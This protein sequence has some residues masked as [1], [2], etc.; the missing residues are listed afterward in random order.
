MKLLMILVFITGSINCLGFEYDSNNFDSLGKPLNLVEMP[1][2][3][4]NFYGDITAALP[5]RKNTV[6]VHPDYFT[7]GNTTV[8]LGL[9]AEDVKVTFLHEGAG[10]KNSFGYIA[11]TDTQPTIDDIKENGILIFPNASLQ[12]SGGN[13]AYGDTYSLGSFPQGTKLLFFV[14]ANTWNNGSIAD[15]S[16]IFTTDSDLNQESGDMNFIPLKQHVAMLW[17]EESE[18]VVLG[19]EDVL[20]TESWCD[21][22]FNDVMFTVS[23]VPANAINSNIITAV[24]EPTAINDNITYSSGI[25]AYEDLWPNTGDYDFN[26]I[27]MFYTIAQTKVNSDVVSIKYEVTPQAMGA[28]FSNKYQLKLNTPLENIKNIQKSFNGDAFDFVKDGVVVNSNLVF[29]DGNGTVIEMI[30][31][32]KGAIPPP[33]NYHMSNTIKNS[34]AVFGTKIT[35][36]IVFYNGVHADTLGAP[37]YDSYISRIDDQGRLIEVHQVGKAPTTKADLSL[38]GTGDDDSNPATGKYY[39]TYDNKPWVI[40]IPGNWDNPLEKI[41]IDQPYSDLLQWIVSNGSNNKDWYTKNINNALI[42]RK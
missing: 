35:L 40:L 30:D 1:S 34:P 32:V 22:D 4:S 39:Q 38:F 26:D 42:F 19:F 36:D 23:S 15:T 28:T 10:F 31:N 3:S 18:V 27:V 41:S 20:R 6:S 8:D 13:L 25:L 17:H 11:Y 29:S 2:F 7:S 21:H 12:N 14:M 16:W 5:E 37:P 9:N 24:P 33:D